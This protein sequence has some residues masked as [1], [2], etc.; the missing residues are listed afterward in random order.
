MRAEVKV[1]PGASRNDIRKRPEGNY[2]AFVTAAPEKGK[3]TEAVIKLLS[4]HF[5]IR[6]SG[7]RLV[8]GVTSKNKVFDIGGVA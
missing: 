8:K 5:G 1:K 2:E 7:V 3:A 4:D 6:K